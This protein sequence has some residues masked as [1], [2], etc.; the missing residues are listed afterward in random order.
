MPPRTRFPKNLPFLDRDWT[1]RT[2]VI[3]II[4]IIA[5]VAVGHT[6]CIVTLRPT[7]TYTLGPTGY[8][9]RRHAQTHSHAHASHHRHQHSRPEGISEICCFFFFYNFYF[10]YLLF[11]YQLISIILISHR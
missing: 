7:S 4:T 9:E 10:S 3:I 5:V 6:H 1:F 8:G 11:V 2:M